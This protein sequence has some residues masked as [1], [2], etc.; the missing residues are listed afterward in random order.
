MENEI[1][2]N[3]S[4]ML[5]DSIISRVDTH[6]I[7]S[8]IGRCKQYQ[9][10]VR[11]NHVLGIFSPDFFL[12]FILKHFKLMTKIEFLLNYL[13]QNANQRPPSPL[14]KLWKK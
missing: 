9:M 14:I 4:F 2:S 10:E 11:S 13:R 7:E 1:E 8:L 5:M 3:Q 12:I 6:Y